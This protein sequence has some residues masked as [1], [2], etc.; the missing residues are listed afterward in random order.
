MVALRLRLNDREDFFGIAHDPGDVA[1]DVGDVASDPGGVAHDLDSVAVEAE[2]MF[3]NLDQ[4]PVLLVCGWCSA[5]CAMI[6]SLSILPSLG[7]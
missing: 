7:Y 2:V 1:S 3:V 6:F 5:N 4:S